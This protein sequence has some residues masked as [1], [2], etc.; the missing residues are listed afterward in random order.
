MSISYH[1]KGDAGY[2]RAVRERYYQQRPF[3]LRLTSQ[4]SIVGVCLVVP[5][6]YAWASDAAWKDGASVPRK[7]LRAAGST[8]SLYNIGLT[9]LAQYVFRTASCC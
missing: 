9:I 7:A 3:L 5:W 2:F 4:F 6:I 1:I 8:D